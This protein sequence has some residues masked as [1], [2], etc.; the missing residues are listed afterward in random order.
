[1]SGQAGAA[2]DAQLEYSR[3]LHGS[4]HGI[5]LRKATHDIDVGDICYW[6]QDGKALRILN[7]FSNKQVTSK[8]PQ[9]KRNMEGSILICFF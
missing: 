3:L 8:K 2:M 9:Q 4:S 5:A 7:I 1:M 6:T